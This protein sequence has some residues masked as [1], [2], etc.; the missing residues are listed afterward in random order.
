VAGG[1]KISLVAVGDIML[2]DGV[3]RIRR[4]VRSTWHDH[5]V[6]QLLNHL[7]PV[8]SGSDLC[9]GN[10]E[11]MVGEV[12]PANPW[13]MTYKG[14]AAHLG[15]LKALGFTH[16][17]LANNHVLDEGLAVDQESERLTAE[18]GVTPLCGVEPQRTVIDGVSVDF[19]TFNLIRDHAGAGFYRDEVSEKDFEIIRASDADV[20]VVCI[21]WGDEYSEYP[22]PSQIDLAHK[23]VDSGI[24][25]VLGHHPHVVQG[26]ERYKD[27]VIAYSLGNFVFDMDWSVRTRSALILE[28]EIAG[29]AVTKSK[30]TYV[31]SGKDYVPQP[32]RP[33]SDLLEVYRNV[34]R[35]VDQPNDYSSYSQAALRKA[36]IQALINLFSRFYA[37]H[38]KTWEIL[39]GR[40]LQRIFPK[41]KHA[42][43]N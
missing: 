33:S 16:L 31:E 23:F 12:H 19:F 1:F 39:F 21:H 35:F 3:Q 40:R 37:V 9:I 22:S 10:L 43:A 8:L 25:A 27:S 14:E 38:P 4:G 20:K 18:A 5:K 26:V 42:Y 29:K 13:L 7:K 41:M 6:D 36:R 34:L 24:Q 11:C 15:E 17:S 30:T 2:G 32:V 28:L